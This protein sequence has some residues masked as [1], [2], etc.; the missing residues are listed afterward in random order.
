MSFSS[1]I[2]YK[3]LKPHI[4]DAIKESCYKTEARI[5]NIANEVHHILTYSVQPGVEI[6]DGLTKIIDQTIKESIGLGCDLSVIVKGIL[7]GAFRASPFM[8]EEA[9]KTI[10]ILIKEIL[11]PVFKYKGDVKKTVEGILTAIVIIAREFKLNIQ[12]ALVIAKE[13]IQ[14][15]AQSKSPEFADEVKAVL[16]NLNE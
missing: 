9:H 13:D 6:A 11:S 14:S 10:G 15:A 8:R 7:L 1:K 12:E 2:I 5:Y 16:P 3:D 4:S